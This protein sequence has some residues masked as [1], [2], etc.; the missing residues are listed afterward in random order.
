MANSMRQLKTKSRH[1]NTKKFSEQITSSFLYTITRYG[2]PPAAD[3]MGLY[4]KEMASLGFRSVELEGIGIDHLANVYAKRKTIKEALVQ[5]ELSLP[6][7]CAVLPGLGSADPKVRRSNL[8]AFEQGCELAA[9]LEAPGILDNGPLI[10]YTFPKDM[11]IHRHYSIDVLPHV[12][13]PLDLVWKEYW[14]GLTETFQ[15]ACGIAERYGLKYYLHPCIG[16]LTETT[17]GFLLLRSAV[18]RDNLRFNLDTANQFFA[19]E[20]L[21]LALM[22]LEGQLDY[23][24]IS[25]NHGVRVEHL[26]PGDGVIDWDIFFSTLQTIK[27]KGHLS[28]DVGG[29]ESG[30]K[31][32]DDAYLHTANWLEQ[33]M[34]EYEIY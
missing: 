26:S 33:K 24:H 15:L 31:N 1:M 21:A 28:I 34:K 20:N 30:I 13:L 3:R 2:Y 17:D 9:Y 29:A 23:I 11:E 5:Q 16:S 14:Q 19:R 25:D 8:N 7:F 10:P 18:E 4:L 12:R 32:I 22:K 27:F 6:V